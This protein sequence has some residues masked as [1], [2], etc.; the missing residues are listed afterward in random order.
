MSGVT[1]VGSYISAGFNQ[2]V[3]VPA[4]LD[5]DLIVFHVGCFYDDTANITV[6]GTTQAVIVGADEGGTGRE[7]LNALFYCPYASGSYSAALTGAANDYLMTAL[8]F[9]GVDQVNPLSLPVDSGAMI[10]MA[11]PF[12]IALSALVAA[13]P[14]SMLVIGNTN[15]SAAAAA[16]DISNGTWT[17]VAGP[18]VEMATYYRSA[19]AGAVGTINV[20]TGGGV[21]IGGAVALTVNPVATLYPLF[22]GMPTFEQLT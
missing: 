2:P 19:V 7:T 17:G 12:D 15:W 3:T 8:V 21:D 20:T 1:F 6:A 4:A 13:R 10:T 16:A 18:S 11:V 22:F 14:D 5:A 9:K